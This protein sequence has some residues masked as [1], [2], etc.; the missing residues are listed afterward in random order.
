VTSALRARGSQLE[1]EIANNALKSNNALKLNQQQLLS[2]TL[3][4]ADTIHVVSRGYCQQGEKAPQDVNLNPTDTNLIVSG[5]RNR[6]LRDLNNFAV[7]LYT[8]KLGPKPLVDYLQ[9]FL[10]KILSNRASTSADKVL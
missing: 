5:K 1:G 3:S 4:K 9:V 10:T 8:A 7:Q 6:K 2:S